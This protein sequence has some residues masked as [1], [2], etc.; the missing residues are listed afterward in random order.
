MKGLIE[1]CGSMTHLPVFGRLRLAGSARRIGLA[2]FLY[3]FSLQ[4]RPVCEWP[5]EAFTGAADPIVTCILG[6]ESI[7]GHSVEGRAL[8]LRHIRR[9][10]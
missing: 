9:S 6:K 3:N 1:I 8:T 2:A 5:A 7:N 10:G 4:L